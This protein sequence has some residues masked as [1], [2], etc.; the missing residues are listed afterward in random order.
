MEILCLF[1][2]LACVYDYG[3]RRIPNFLVL[4]CFL[5]GLGR[6]YLK[7][8]LGRAGIYLAA[9][10]TVMC[11]LYPA[12]KIGVLGAGDVKLFAVCAGYF[13]VGKI[14]EF[15]FMSLG[16]AA[17]AAVFKIGKERSWKKCIDRF[18]SYMEQLA[19]GEWR[20]YIEDERERRAAGIC[21]A[22]PMLGSAL[23]YW[24]G[25]F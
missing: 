18:A 21:L 3:W 6:T 7:Q 13:P 2:V 11:I 14:G 10:V 24:G 25:F 23:L 8:G 9:V 12:F 4:V 16:L 5:T 15:L 19:G 22:G 17:V 1:L 20:L